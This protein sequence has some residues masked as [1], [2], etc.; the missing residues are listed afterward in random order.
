MAA[1]P[2]EFDEE[3]EAPPED[4]YITLGFGQPSV[5]KTQRKRCLFYSDD[6]FKVIYWDIIQSLCLLLTCILTP[7]NLA[8]YDSLLEY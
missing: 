8:F 5:D 4:D 1:I 7:F 6:K 3:Q 2:P